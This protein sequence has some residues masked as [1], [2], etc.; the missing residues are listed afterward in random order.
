MRSALIG[1]TGFVGSN[2]LDAHG[3]DDVYNSTNIHEIADHD[4][5]LVVSAGNRADSFRIN[6]N[7][8]ADRAEVDALVDNV[9]SA[10]IAKLVLISTVCVYPGGGSP[11]ESIALS[12]RGLTPYGANRLHQERRFSDAVNTTC[13]RLP[14]LYGARLKKGVVYDLAHHYRVEHIRPDVQFQHYD[15]RRLWGDI[16]VALNNGLSSVNI[17]TPP[18]T[19]ADLALNVFDRDIS[20]HVPSEP[21]SAFAQ[22]YTRNM[23]T[24]HAALFDSTDDYLITREEELASLRAFA[25]ELNEERN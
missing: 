4:Y 16:N 21:E 2:L 7:G 1:Y 3:F 6:N 8:A 11:D 9:L 12:E 17:A 24:Q 25:V 20:G 19:N 22:M 10:R 15:V 14:Q 18:I 13:V 23:T 5:D